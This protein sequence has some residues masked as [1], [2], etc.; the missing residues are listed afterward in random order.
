VEVSRAFDLSSA[1]YVRLNVSLF[2]PMPP[3]SSMSL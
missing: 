3:H 2:L 1:F